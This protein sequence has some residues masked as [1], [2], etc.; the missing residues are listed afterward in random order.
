MLERVPPKRLRPAFALVPLAALLLW[1][2]A[3]LIWSYA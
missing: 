1:A 3:I 2:A